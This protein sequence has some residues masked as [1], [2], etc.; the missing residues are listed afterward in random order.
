MQSPK[1][2]PRN[3]Q[4]RLTDCVQQYHRQQKRVHLKSLKLQST[5]KINQ[6]REI[7]SCSCFFTQSLVCFCRILRIIGKRLLLHN[8][9]SCL[10][11]DFAIDER[12]S[13][14]KRAKRSRRKLNWILSAEQ[15]AS[16]FTFVRSTKLIEHNLFVNIFTVH[17]NDVLVGRD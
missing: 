7:F 17:C 13:N 16:A 12:P 11:T 15:T 8:R 5:K 9:I 6:Q 2:R 4:K 10:A 3:P 14:L 1:T